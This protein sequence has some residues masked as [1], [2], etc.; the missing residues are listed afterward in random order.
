MDS[1]DEFIFSKKENKNESTSTL[2]KDFNN[3]FSWAQNW[4]QTYEREFPNYLKVTL[5]NNMIMF[6]FCPHPRCHANRSG[7]SIGFA[8]S[9]EKVRREIDQAYKMF[10]EIIKKYLYK[11]EEELK[12][13]EKED[14]LLFEKLSQKTPKCVGL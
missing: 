4:L 8:Q 2:H 5:N 10:C 14:K 9:Y 1:D 11:Y 6:S 7:H 3:N 12:I 13:C